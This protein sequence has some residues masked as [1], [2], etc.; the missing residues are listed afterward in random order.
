MSIE[1]ISV[2]FA[3]QGSQEFKKSNFNKKAFYFVGFPAV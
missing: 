3:T 2:I 1:I